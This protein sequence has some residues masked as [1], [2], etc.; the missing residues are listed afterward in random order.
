M[1]T[2]LFVKQQSGGMFSIL[3]REAFPNGNV[4]W[5]GS[6]VTGA[7]NGT[8]YGRNPD[9]PFATLLYAETQVAAGDTIYL[10]PGH[11]EGLGDAQIDLDVAN[12]TVIGLGTGSKIPRIDFDHANASIDIGANDVTLKNIAL[13]PSITT[14]LIG[15]DIEAGK[16]GTVLEDIVVLPGEDGAGADEFVLAIDLK[17]GCHDTTIRRFVNHMHASSA[18]ADAG[19]SLTGASHRVRIEDCDIKVLGAAAVAPIKGITTLSTDIRIARCVLV[20][21]AEP[22]IELLTGTTGVVA[23]NCIFSN[24]T[25]VVDAI[26]ADGCALFENYYVEVGSEAGALIGTP[27]ANDGG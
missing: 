4:W 27:S 6:T 9:A 7:T 11:N 13:L 5:V 21:D 19:I 20:S 8:G 15:I 10:L 12:L 1:D 25:N 2:K 26:V 22:G 18:H 16:T 17:A 3:D 24:L 23:N 14:V